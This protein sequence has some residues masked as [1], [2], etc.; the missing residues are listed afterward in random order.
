M[1]DFRA[2]IQEARDRTQRA[3]DERLRLDL[4]EEQ[5]LDA[6]RLSI[7]PNVLGAPP[8]LVPELVSTSMGAIELPSTESVTNVL[9][10]PTSPVEV[11]QP[12]EAQPTILAP[13]GPSTAT[14]YANLL[15][16]KKRKRSKVDTGSIRLHST[17]QSN[18]ESEGREENL[19]RPH[20][21]A[22]KAPRGARPAE[23]ER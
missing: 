10:S 4:I 9:G 19:R 15:P 11:E 20:A 13:R 2:A 7:A 18:T 16:A 12:E 22:K 3:F 23:S 1:K 6:G 14:S 17:K 21:P 5:S 8:Q